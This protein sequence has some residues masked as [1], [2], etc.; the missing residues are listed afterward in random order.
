VHFVPMNSRVTIGRG[1]DNDIVLQDGGSTV[2][3]FH[4][5]FIADQHNVWIDDYK[6][7]NGT[8]VAGREITAPTLLE[9]DCEIKVGLY[10]L[11]FRRIKEN[12][13]LA[14]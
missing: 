2:S 1:D 7:L 6:S 10:K 13:I 12:T 9:T 8:I 4:C 5:G 14:Q 3:R 11:Y